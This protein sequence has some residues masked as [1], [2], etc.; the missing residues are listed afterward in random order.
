MCFCVHK[1]LLPIRNWKIIFGT[2][3]KK[4]K[5]KKG[6]RPLLPEDQKMTE[7]I[8][9]RCTKKDKEML[10]KIAIICNLSLSEYLTKK[11]LDERIVENRIK[12]IDSL[13]TVQLELARGGNNINQLAKH[14]NQIKKIDGLD[15]KM[16][17]RYNLLLNSYVKNMYSLRTIFKGIYRELA[18]K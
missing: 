1:N 4:M 13:N 12:I 11:G 9:L 15:E 8:T 16:M 5:R 2:Q 14:A 6:G 10:K 17:F 3:I 18:K 7:R